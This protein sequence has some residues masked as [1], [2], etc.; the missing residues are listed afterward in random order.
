[1]DLKRQFKN[2]RPKHPVSELD[3]HVQNDRNWRYF[4]HTFI[5]DLSSGLGAWISMV[6]RYPEEEGGNA[7]SGKYSLTHTTA[8][9]LHKHWR[10][11]QASAEIRSYSLPLT[12][13]EV[14]LRSESNEDP[15]QAHQ[16]RHHQV[17]SHPRVENLLLG[18]WRPTEEQENLSKALQLD[19]REEQQQRSS[20][21]RS[22]GGGVQVHPI[23]GHL[24]AQT[25][26]QR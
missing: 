3:I 5:S 9:P 23:T 21:Q 26:N 25:E 8:A 15:G 13:S 1:M 7:D 18:A 12:F 19:L 11:S 16:Q 24:L 4:H 22:V 6:I 10:F 2:G 17:N 14:L 20:P